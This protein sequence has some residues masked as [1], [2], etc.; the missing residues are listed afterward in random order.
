VQKKVLVQ[1]DGPQ[2]SSDAGKKDDEGVCKESGIDDQE[3]LENSTQSINT[4]PDM[5]SLGDNATLEATH[6]DFFVDET[7][8]DIRNITT[9]Y[10]VP[11]T[12]DTRI[13]K[14]HSLNHVIGDVQSGVQ[15]RR[16]IKT[17]NEQG[18]ISV[19]YEGKTHEDL[20]TCLFAYFL[21]QEE[22]KRISKYNTLC[23]QVIDD[24]NKSA[25]CLLYCTCLLEIVNVRLNPVRQILLFNVNGH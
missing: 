22:P 4:E 2:P 20:H 21:S 6:A 13:H 19:V 17:T 5:C 16:L 12:P 18:F 24:V 8:V 10:P 23:F 15:T 9:T 1:Y 3:R 11:S 7:S 14:D 25:I